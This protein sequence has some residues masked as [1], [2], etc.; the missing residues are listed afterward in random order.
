MS[1]EQEDL[2][3]AIAL[4]KTGKKSE[5]VPILKNIL[6]TNRDNELAWLWLAYCVGTPE[7][8]IYCFREVLR[9]NPSNER[10]KKALEQ[11]EPNPTLQPS[12]EELSNV[13][14]IQNKPKEKEDV[15][16][17][18]NHTAPP[19]AQ[20]IQVQNVQTQPKKRSSLLWYILVTILIFGGICLYA[21]T[22]NSNSTVTMAKFNQIQTGMSYQQ[23]VKLIG[24]QGEEISRSDLAGLTTIMYMWKNSDGSNMN[25]MFQNDQLIA[26]AQFGLK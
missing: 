4:I 2:K 22:I 23:V 1:Q 13:T 16:V 18:P 5:A 10:V 6:K 24:E 17:L 25:T 8:K 7:D 26:K 19:S 11:I 9:I 3:Q 20:P 12:I 14:S 21:T 15:Q